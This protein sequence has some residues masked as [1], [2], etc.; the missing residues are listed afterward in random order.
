MRH[1]L[2][3][4]ILLTVV[5]PA[6]GQLVSAT[7]ELAECAAF[8]SAEGTTPSPMLSIPGYSDSMLQLSEVATVTARRLGAQERRWQ[9]AIASRLQKYRDII[10]RDDLTEMN[11]YSMRCGR[12]LRENATADDHERARGSRRSSQSPGHI[13]GSPMPSALER[14]PCDARRLAYLGGYLTMYGRSAAFAANPRGGEEYLE[15]SRS[16]RSFASNGDVSAQQ[17]AEIAERA[18]AQAH[19]DLLSNPASASMEAQRLV[20]EGVLMTFGGCTAGK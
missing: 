6:L 15:L 20:T 3:L 1:L 10:R 16:F 18:G 4:P 5:V 12:V 8:Y 19:S 9:L 14:V 17:I 7:D 13:V 11:I 2:V